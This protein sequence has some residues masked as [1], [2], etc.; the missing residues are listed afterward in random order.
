MGNG[1][2]EAPVDRHVTPQ[3]PSLLSEPIIAIF[4]IFDYLGLP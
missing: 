3:F 2:M 4:T 1:L